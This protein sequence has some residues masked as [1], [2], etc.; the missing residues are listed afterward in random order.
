MFPEK[1]DTSSYIPVMGRTMT[2]SR[3]VIVNMSDSEMQSAE[4]K[5]WASSTHGLRKQIS[6]L[7]LFKTLKILYVYVFLFCYESVYIF[8]GRPNNILL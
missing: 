1:R 5:H 3:Q 7:S 4:D 8:L 6:I 2:I